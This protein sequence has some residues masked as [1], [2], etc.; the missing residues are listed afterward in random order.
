MARF[1]RRGKT[2]IWFL[3]AVSNK[4]APSSAEIT[5]GTE[6][7][8]SIQAISGFQ[9]ANTPI[10]TPDL[11][12]TFN[13][14]IP[15]EDAAGNSSLTMYDDDASSAV[16]TAL[17]KNTA[18]FLLFGPYGI[19]TGKRAEVWPV[20]V[21]SNSDEYTMGNEA[22]RFMVGFSVTSIPTQ[23]AVMP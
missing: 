9:L 23:N 2:R 19:T 13:S 16:K 22:A 4:S 20:T 5:A 12:T 1:F 21:T 3:P 7:T 6:L 15:G 11:Q 10:S 17:A 8:G 18:G 14:E